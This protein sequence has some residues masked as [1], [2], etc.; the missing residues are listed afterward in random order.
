[1]ASWLD[2]SLRYVRFIRRFARLIVGLG[3]LLV[4]FKFDFITSFHE[5]PGGS[6]K[7]FGPRTAPN[8]WKEVDLMGR[9]GCLRPCVLGGGGHS[10]RWRGV[11]N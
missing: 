8:R 2:G 10:L 11:T 7:S 6:I 9:T 4:A 1:M 3:V 5:S